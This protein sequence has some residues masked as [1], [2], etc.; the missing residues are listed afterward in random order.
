MTIRE[1]TVADERERRAESHR[2]IV[3][4]YHVVEEDDHA[5]ELR[6]SASGS[7][8]IHIVLLF[9]TIGIGNVVY[10]IKKLRDADH[11]RIVE[12]GA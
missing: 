1:L 11:V 5:T 2:L 6:E 4:G 10:W 9:M 3:D 12:A 8:L 7:A